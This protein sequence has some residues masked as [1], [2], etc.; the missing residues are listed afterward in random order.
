MGDLLRKQKSNHKKHT[1]PAY[2]ENGTP[3]VNSPL[4]EAL[5]S[6]QLNLTTPLLSSK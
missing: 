6:R 5:V 2:K 1:N 4:M 3:I